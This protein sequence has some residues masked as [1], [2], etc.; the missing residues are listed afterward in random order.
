ME[1]CHLGCEQ[2]VVSPLCCHPVV[3]KGL[4]SFAVCQAVCDGET[5]VS[6]QLRQNHQYLSGERV[7]KGD[8]S[9]T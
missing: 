9:V 8:G 3:Q 6:F 2:R 7:E 5:S 4:G 1:P